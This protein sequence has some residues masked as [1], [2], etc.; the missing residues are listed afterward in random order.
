[1]HKVEEHNEKISIYLSVSSHLLT[2]VKS[3]LQG[4]KFFTG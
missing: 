2:R 3:Y 4:Q 1:M